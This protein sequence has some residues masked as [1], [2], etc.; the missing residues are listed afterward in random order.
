MIVSKSLKNK[1]LDVAILWARNIST[2]TTRPSLADGVGGGGQ[3]T[4]PVSF[5]GL[6]LPTST[7]VG[8]FV[9]VGMPG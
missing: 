4:L 7:V 6:P 9:F 5:A 1:L 3:C 2:G 8:R